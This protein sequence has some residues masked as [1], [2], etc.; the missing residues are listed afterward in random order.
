MLD[1]EAGAVG[2]WRIRDNGIQG[3][4]CL[5]TDPLIQAPGHDPRMPRWTGSTRLSLRARVV[6]ADLPA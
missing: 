2:T 3:L 1:A 6:G 4:A 5:C